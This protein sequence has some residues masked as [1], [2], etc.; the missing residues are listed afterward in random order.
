MVDICYCPYDTILISFCPFKYWYRQESPPAGNRTRRTACSI[1]CPGRGGE[2]CTP[3][4]DREGLPLSWL[5]DTPKGPGTRDVGK[6]WDWGTPQV[7]TDKQTENI[8][9]SH[10]SDAGSNKPSFTFILKLSITCPDVEFWK[11]QYDLAPT[12]IDLR[13]LAI[14]AS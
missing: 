3:V 12:S 1:T 5:G 2:G 4:L 6:T 13:L 14:K 11:P 10:P 9:L 8:T 7:W